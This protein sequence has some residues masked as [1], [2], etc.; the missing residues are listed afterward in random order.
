MSLR[1][2]LIEAVNLARTDSFPVFL[3]GRAV[4]RIYIVTSD[5]IEWLSQGKIEDSEN[6]SVYINGIEPEKLTDKNFKYYSLENDPEELSS[7]DKQAL[8]SSFGRAFGYF[9][10]IRYS[11]HK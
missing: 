10:P 5:D 7:K 6:Y 4:G 3:D 8:A 9:D 2:V 11:R 1:T